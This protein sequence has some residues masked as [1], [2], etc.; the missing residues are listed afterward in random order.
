MQSSAD[1]LNQAWQV[2]QRGGIAQAEQVYRSVLQREP[3]NANAWCFWG[4]AMHDMRRYDEAIS[5]YENAIQLQPIFPS[6]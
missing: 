2:H 3:N 1:Q 6:L 5:A 4:I